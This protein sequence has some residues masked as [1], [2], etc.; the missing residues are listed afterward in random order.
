MPATARLFRVPCRCSATVT[1]GPGQAG[2]HLTCPACGAGIDVPRLRDLAPFA[3]AAERPSGPRWRAAH[4][5]LLVGGLVAAAA[6]SAAGLVGSFDGGASVRLP[7]ERFIRQAIEAADAATIH[8]AWRAI[9]RSS[10]D[11]GA[12]PVELLVQRAASSAGRIAILLWAVAALGGLAALGGAVA[13]MRQ[14]ATSGPG[15]SR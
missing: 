6:A 11:R 1:I 4:A 7:D 10:V 3:V 14:R 5:W 13:A 8:A 9:R 12:V 2:S 15:D